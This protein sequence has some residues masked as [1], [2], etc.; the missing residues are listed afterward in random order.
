MLKPRSHLGRCTGGQGV[1][2]AAALPE[3]PIFAWAGAF[4]APGVPPQPPQP[5]PP[6]A[7]EGF[8]FLPGGAS[9]VSMEPTQKLP[10]GTGGMRRDDLSHDF[11]PLSAP[12]I[13]GN[14]IR[15]GLKIQREGRPPLPLP[16]MSPW[17]AGATLGPPDRRDSFPR[18]MGTIDRDPKIPAG[19]QSRAGG[20]PPARHH[21]PRPFPCHLQGH[22]GSRGWLGHPLARPSP[23]SEPRNSSRRL[24][25]ALAQLGRL[26]QLPGRDP[27]AAAVALLGDSCCQPGV[28]RMPE[29]EPQ[30]NPAG[31]ARL[32][33]SVS[34]GEHGGVPA[35]MNP[36]G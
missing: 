2:G 36:P 33:P 26:A 18:G 13:H 27:P 8:C 1:L 28:V 17:R 23:G 3:L 4:G 15:K 19:E 32:E 7:R 29:A 21:H 12:K 9:A 31:N 14:L 6:P 25:S 35:V 10:V 11:I 24:K 16:K 30:G 5:G 22:S 34:V 20:V